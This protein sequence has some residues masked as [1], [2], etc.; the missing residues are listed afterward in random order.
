MTDGTT[1]PRAVVALASFAV[2]CDLGL[3]AGGYEPA[4]SA[5][6]AMVVWGALAM[7]LLAFRPSGLSRLATVSVL[8]M[9]AFAVW[10]GISLLWTESIEQGVHDLGR[11]LLYVG[12]LALAILA[13]RAGAARAMLYGIAAAAGVVLLAAVLSRLLPTL[14]P[15]P[16]D[17]QILT[18]SR[19]QLSYPI[20]YWNALAAFAAVAIP[21]QIGLAAGT[22]SALARGALLSVVPVAMLVIYLT[23]SRGGAV[24]ATVA[25]AAMMVFAPVVRFALLAALAVVPGIAVVVFSSRY[26]A[27]QDGLIDQAVARSQGGSLALVLLVAMLVSAVGGALWRRE[28]TGSVAGGVDAQTL[29]RRS[30]AVATV[31][32]AALAISAL[33]CRCTDQVVDGFKTTAADTQSDTARQTPT[34]QLSSISGRGRYELWSTA[35]STWSSNPVV[36]VGAGSFGFI[37]NRD[38]REGPAARNAHS[39]YLETLA[40]LGLVGAALLAVLAVS[41]GWSTFLRSKQL[42]PPE[43]YAMAGCLGVVTGFGVTA[44]V[45]WVW[46]IPAVTVIALAAAATLLQPPGAKQRS[47]VREPSSRS[48]GTVRI[49]GVGVVTIATL[50]ALSFAALALGERELEQANTADERTYEEAR[51]R[52]DRASAILPWSVEARIRR[53]LLSSPAEGIEYVDEALRMEPN[54]WRPWFVRASLRA[55]LGEQAEALSDYDRATRLNRHAGQIISPRPRTN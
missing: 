2:V 27:V 37:W 30:L 8:A 23:A 45:D 49:V 29:H 15:T 14:V 17:M 39:H 3:R 24:A 44:A 48:T 18:E 36:G 40:E 53:A 33:S 54:N 55:E 50:L 51:Q 26:P 7:L 10:T 16:E 31:L 5:E 32:M 34:D 38:T 21:L 1:K 9:I 41:I 52:A 28:P 35:A 22:R 19:A 6:L 42:P 13:A 4:V 12:V 20:G 43:R 46:E 11:A 25:I 47:A